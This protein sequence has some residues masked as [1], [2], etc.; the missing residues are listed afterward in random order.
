MAERLDNVKKGALFLILGETFTVGMA[1]IFKKI[2][3]DLPFPTIV[4]FRN[5]FGFI[6]I[7]IFLLSSR[8]FN[9]KTK[10]IHWHF[11]R[12]LVGVSGM[13]G[14]F[15]VI[16][17]MKLAEASMVKLTVPFFLPIISYFW[18]KEKIKTNHFIAL[19][20]GFGGVTVLLQP[21]TENF[22]PIVFIGLLAAL[23]QSIAKVTIRK[24]SLTEPFSRVIFYFGLF[25]TFI[26]LIPAL[27][28]WELP[29]LNML[30]SLVLLGVFG[31]AGQIF[32]TKAYLI[33]SPG[34]IGAYT[35]TSLITSSLLG[36]FFWSETL[37][38]YIFA[39]SGLIISAGL[40]N[41]YNKK[42]ISSE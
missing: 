37:S 39:G 22:Q 32:I 7:V 1:A 33:A 14:M 38:W 4:F 5:F 12:A 3:T 8:N 17:H 21:G 11:L 6:A 19:I 26:S 34:K 35:Y 15:Y 31:T 18:L 40:I 2:D 20:V 28:D 27:F 16:L 30:I 42:E 36:W 9:V 10:V 29:N 13:F 25:G 23:L 41:L 24:M